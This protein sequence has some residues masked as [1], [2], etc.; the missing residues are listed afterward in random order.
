MNKSLLLI[1]VV[2]LLISVHFGIA[3]DLSIVVNKNVPETTINIPTLQKIFL[4]KKT[5][6]MNDSKI[7][8]V[9]MSKGETR[10]SFL[11]TIGQSNNDFNQ[12]WMKKIFAGEGT[13]PGTFNTE[14]ELIDYVGKNPGSIGYISI[15]TT[16]E[17]VK[18]V[19]LEK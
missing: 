10:D 19:K 2:L 1:S 17:N 11:T 14:A 18:V 5:T 13:P 7:V 12:Y 9:M 3:S 15:A 8:P 4:G 16:N 6:W